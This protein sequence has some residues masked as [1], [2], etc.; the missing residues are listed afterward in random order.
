M[1]WWLGRL[2]RYSTLL[3]RGPVLLIDRLP[4]WFVFKV[5]KFL[6]HFRGIDR[7]TLLCLI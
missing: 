6:R 2:L 3:V 4:I 7:V 5:Y 1:L